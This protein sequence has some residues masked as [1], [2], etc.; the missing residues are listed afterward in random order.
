MKATLETILKKVANPP[1]PQNWVRLI[2]ADDQ[3]S[4]A[5]RIANLA[6]GIPAFNYVIGMKMCHDRV[7]YKLE[8]DTALKATAGYGAPAGREQNGEFVRAFW[9]YDKTRQ[10]SEARCLDSYNGFF[11]ISRH[12]KIPTKPTFTILENK[13][14]IPVVLCGWKTVPLDLSQR[15]IISTVYESG[16]FSYGAYRHSP[17]EIVFF[18]EFETET[19]PQRFAEVW[20]RGDYGTLPASELRDLLEFYSLAQEQAIPIIQEKWA[21]IQEKAREKERLERDIGR[22]EPQPISLQDDF[23]DGR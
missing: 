18:P 7:Q 17:A 2:V 6:L 13:Q 20:R 12:V 3:L 21:K 10:Y 15:R 5:I 4:T 19:G 1:A 9:E 11:P 16:L 22:D 14:Q 23:F 8:L